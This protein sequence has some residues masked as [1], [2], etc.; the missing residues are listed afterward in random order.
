MLWFKFCFGAKFLKLVQL[1][2]P[3]VC[4][5]YHKLEQWQIKLES[6]QKTLNQGQIQT[7]AVTTTT[8][9]AFQ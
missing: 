2:F 1:L 6:V 9:L 4:I 8:T 7:L 5:H 3:F